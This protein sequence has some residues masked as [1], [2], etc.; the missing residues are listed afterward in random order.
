MAALA[1]SA[2]CRKMQEHF[3]F[4]GVSKAMPS[5]A[6]YVRLTPVLPHLLQ[7]RSNTD[8]FSFESLACHPISVS[9]MPLYSSLLLYDIFL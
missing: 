8:L 2:S 9:S 1:A 5:V 6:M 3:V 7:V 4:S